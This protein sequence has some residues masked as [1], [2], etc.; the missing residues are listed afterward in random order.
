MVLSV[1]LAMF[2][3]N[4]TAKML[5]VQEHQGAYSARAVGQVSRHEESIADFAGKLS[6]GRCIFA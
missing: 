4:K 3:S 2:G 5:L 1:T 6:A